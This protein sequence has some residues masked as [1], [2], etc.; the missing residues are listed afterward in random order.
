MP[1]PVVAIVGR[2]SVGKSALFNRLIGRRMA[3]VENLPGLTRDRQYATTSWRD[4]E[5]HLIDTGGFVSN[6]SEPMQ[7]QVRQQT[8]R[9]IDEADA[10]LFVLDARTG[11]LPEDREVAQ[12]LREGRRPVLV[13]ANKSDD[14]DTPSVYEFYELGLGDPIAV[15]AV[16]GLGINDLLDALVAL[17]PQAE[18]VED[19]SQTIHVAVV[20]RPNVGKSSLVNVI[21]GEE[22]V[23]VDVMPGT[24][25]DAIDTPFTHDG[26]RFVL[27]DTAGLRRK[28]RIAGPVERYSA[29]RSLH[30]IDRAEVTVLVLDASDS[31]ANQDQEIA[32]YTQEQ[33]RALVFVLNKWDLVS[34]TPSAHPAALA[35]VRQA[36]RFVGY[37]PIVITSATRGWGLST[38]MAR[39]VETAEAHDRRIATGPLNRAVELAE[40]AHHAPADRFGRQLKIFYATQ[41]RAKP[42]TIVLFCNDPTLIT[43]DYRRYLESRLRKTFDFLGTPIRLVARR[44]ERGRIE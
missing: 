30:A 6:A 15:S 17:L 37:A 43:E 13:V 11:V 26:R 14:P 20:G 21:L 44:R 39:V 28:A 36:M 25:R 23:I 12:H 18:G 5:F 7:A 19:T 3:I 42:P 41:P 16:H 29:D 32:R 10:I 31:L 40:Q 8:E 22:R 1:P 27:I 34:T 9:A 24:T 4:R 2:P 33:G 38:L 35:A